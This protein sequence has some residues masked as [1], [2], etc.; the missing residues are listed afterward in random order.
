MVEYNVANL[1][2]QFS[3]LRNLRDLTLCPLFDVTFS[4]WIESLSNSDSREEISDIKQNYNFNSPTESYTF[5]VDGK[6]VEV[7][8]YCRDVDIKDEDESWYMVSR[9]CFYGDEVPSEKLSGR[10]SEFVERQNLEELISKSKIKL[11]EGKRDHLSSE[12]LKFYF[13]D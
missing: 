12:T 1:R 11:E 7:N 3:K 9:V 6:I 10:F 8:G 13:R 5:V 4:D 2:N